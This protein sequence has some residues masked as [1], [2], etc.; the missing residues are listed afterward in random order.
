MEMR[1]EPTVYDKVRS[2]IAESTELP[3]ILITSDYG[4]E[5]DSY[6][7][8]IDDIYVTSLLFPHE[9]E[10]MYGDTFGLDEGKYYDDIDDVSEMVENYWLWD[11]GHGFHSKT[12]RIGQTSFGASTAVRDWIETYR[13]I[14]RMIAEDMPWHKYVVISGR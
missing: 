2:V 8:D 10:R 12:V 5:Y 3:I 11:N 6:Y 4:G 9:V 13:P 1:D 14:A 7:H